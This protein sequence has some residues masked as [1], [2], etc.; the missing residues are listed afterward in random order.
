MPEWNRLSDLR[1]WDLTANSTRWDMATAA[2]SSETL[3]IQ[4]AIL[5]F[6]NSVVALSCLL[7]LVAIFRV[8]TVREKAFNCYLAAITLPDFVGSFSCVITCA[9]SATVSTYYSEVM[10]GWQT[11]YLVWGFTANC[12]MNAVIAHQLYKMLRVSHFR[13]RYHPPTRKRV[14]LQALC[15]YLYAAVIATLSTWN[16]PA[17]PLRAGSYSGFACFPK[18]Y[19]VP[20]SI[21]FWLVF[22]PA[23]LLIPLGYVLVCV[24][25]VF[26]RGML[27][28]IGRRRNLAVYFFRLVFVFVAMWLPFIIIAFIVGPARPGVESSWLPWTSAAW[29]TSLTKPD[30]KNAYLG[31]PTFGWWDRKVERKKAGSAKRRGSSTRRNSSLNESEADDDHN[32]QR[33]R[34]TMSFS[35]RKSLDF[36][37]TG[38]PNN[39]TNDQPPSDTRAATRDSFISQGGQSSRSIWVES[40]ASAAERMVQEEAK[41]EEKAEEKAEIDP[42]IPWLKPPKN[43]KHRKIWRLGVA[44]TTMILVLPTTKTSFRMKTWRPMFVGNSKECKSAGGFIY[45]LIQYFEMHMPIFL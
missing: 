3:H 32:K 17:V 12:W 10:C 33:R 41:E 9:M 6:I 30:I 5:A 15:V 34:A 18:G 24:I 45:E 25:I 16:I 37:Y 4:F 19:D 26:R 27:P 8:K 44:M 23:F 35:I 40:G 22:V 21:F 42:N 39:E 13:G 43:G 1:V 14:A 31:T 29:I 20:S 36:L 2:P 7:L 28:P 38:R 11:F